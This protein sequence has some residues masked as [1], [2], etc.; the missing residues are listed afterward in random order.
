MRSR[1]SGTKFFL[2][3]LVFLMFPLF[4]LTADEPSKPVET[5]ILDR[6]KTLESLAAQASREAEPALNL[7]KAQ[8]KSAL[9][10]AK[11]Q[12]KVLTINPSV[13]QC[14]DG[15]DRWRTCIEAAREIKKILAASFARHSLPATEAE[16]RDRLKNFAADVT[17]QGILKA[18]NDE[19]IKKVLELHEALSRA[20]GKFGAVFTQASTTT[21]FSPMMKVAQ[22]PISEKVDLISLYTQSFDAAIAEL[23]LPK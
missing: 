12:I 11:L 10:E 4:A 19:V 23:Q 8:V 14:N 2:T 18:L 20:I 6:L 21:I 3:A 13:Q 15:V 17:N 5:V 7:Y 1:F 16:L 22:R 9:E